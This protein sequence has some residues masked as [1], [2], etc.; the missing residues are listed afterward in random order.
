MPRSSKWCPSLGS[1][2]Q[3]PLL[4]RIHATC[5]A[6]ADNKA[7]AERRISETHHPWITA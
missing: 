4:P 1:R 5:L 7:P 2:H 6:H 3:I